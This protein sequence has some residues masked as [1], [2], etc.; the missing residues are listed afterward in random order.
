MIIGLLNLYI[1]NYL[2]QSLRDADSSSF[3]KKKEKHFS[4]FTI[5]VMLSYLSFHS[6]S[7]KSVED[8]GFNPPV[9]PLFIGS[10]PCSSSPLSI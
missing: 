4:Q 10:L 9:S 3:F 7:V 8:I 5:D 1:L 2:T 6:L